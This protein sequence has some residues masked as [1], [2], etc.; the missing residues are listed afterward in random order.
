MKRSRLLTNLFAGLVHCVTVALIAVCC[1]LIVNGI[2][3]HYF[4]YLLAA[5]VALAVWFSMP[6]IPKLTYDGILLSRQEH[7]ALYAL[8]DDI[9]DQMRLPRIN[10]LILDHQF[11]AS[12]EQSGWRMKR[13]V[14]LGLP[15]FG[16][17][18]REE[19]IALI[20]H[21]GQS[22]CASLFLHVIRLSYA[23]SLA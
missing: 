14:T 1:Y 19:K 23:D 8:V 10:G 17:L 15:L 20:G 18:N 5:I 7:G 4:F 9:C 12:Y 3:G 16:I 2:Q 11:N 21:E 6:R 13:Y 22:R